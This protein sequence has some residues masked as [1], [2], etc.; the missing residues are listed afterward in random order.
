M[1]G[2]GAA[3]E[4]ASFRERLRAGGEGF[5]AGGGVDGEEGADAARGDGAAAGFY[6][7]VGVYGE[8][9]G[10]AEIG[11]GGHAALLV[12]AEA[13]KLAMCVALSRFPMRCP[14]GQRKRS[15]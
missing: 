12:V 1:D 4:G 13:Y 3:E 6:G 10:A 14:G 2:E 11:E 5:E 7:M 8:A 9:E 15:R